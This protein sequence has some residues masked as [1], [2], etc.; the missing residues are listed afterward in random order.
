MDAAL[1]Y[2]MHTGPGMQ[3]DSFRG[4]R[5]QGVRNVDL[6]PRDGFWS[7]IFRV[8]TPDSG[9]SWRHSSSDRLV[10]PS[11]VS[12]RRAPTLTFWPCNQTPARPSQK[13][14]SQRKGKQKKKRE[15]KRTQWGRASRRLREGGSGSSSLQSTMLQGYPDECSRGVSSRRSE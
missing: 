4:I 1:K 11:G 6:T 15:R 9:C 10:P 13:K 5:Q 2:R 12:S 7:R 3:R 8:L 14:D